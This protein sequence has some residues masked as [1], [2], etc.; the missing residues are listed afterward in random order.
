M[1]R[2]VPSRLVR[3]SRCKAAGMLEYAVA[4]GLIGDAYKGIYMTYDCPACNLMGSA[5]GHVVMV[6]AV[7]SCRVLAV[8]RVS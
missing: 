4:D 5:P 6:L 1:K 3:C 2:F 8:R 7:G